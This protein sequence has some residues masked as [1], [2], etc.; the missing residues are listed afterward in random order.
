MLIQVILNW[1]LVFHIIV[2]GTREVK[3][4]SKQEEERERERDGC[5]EDNKL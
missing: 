3:A 4:H 1:G 5:C 2:F